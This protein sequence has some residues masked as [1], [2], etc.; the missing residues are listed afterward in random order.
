METLQKV[1]IFFNFAKLVIIVKTIIIPYIIF[2][3][4]RMFIRVF[5]NK[6]SKYR[7]IMAKEIERK[8][9]VSDIE[10]VRRL[11]ASSSHIRQ[12][13]ISSNPDATVR[14]RIRDNEAFITVKGR[15]KGA[16]RDEWEFGIPVIDAEEMAERLCGGF[17]IDKTRYIVEVKGWSWEVD[18]FHGKH[19]GLLLAEIEMPSVDSTPEIPPFIGTEVTGDARY[20]NSNLA[21]GCSLTD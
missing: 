2:T 12:A 13:Y 7:Y 19:A 18:E 11:A 3:L 14:L 15:N 9:L 16:V 8:F 17:A 21:K 1:T 4:R 6:I 10:T 20:Y 5:H